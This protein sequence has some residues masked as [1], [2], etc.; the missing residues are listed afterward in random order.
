MPMVATRRMTLG[1]RN[2][3]VITESSSAPAS[4]P[5]AVTETIAAGQNGQS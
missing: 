4:S 1:A 2:S 5:P 3:R